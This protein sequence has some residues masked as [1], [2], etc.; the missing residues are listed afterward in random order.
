MTIYTLDAVDSKLLTL[1]SL[2]QY[3]E[4][5]NLYFNEDAALYLKPES[6]AAL[7]NSAEAFFTIVKQFIEKREM[8]KLLEG[9]ESVIKG[10]LEQNGAESIKIQPSHFLDPSSLFTLITGIPEEGYS[11]FTGIFK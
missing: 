11:A 3:E 6:T 7:R 9:V 10:L 2:S 4:K 8:P 5:S 1:E